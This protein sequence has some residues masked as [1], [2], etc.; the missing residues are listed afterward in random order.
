MRRAGIRCL[1]YIDDA[2]CAL[3]SSAEALAA[4]D[5]IEQMFAGSGLAKTPVK[6]V[7]EPTQSTD[8]L[9]AR[10]LESP[11]ASLPRYRIGCLSLAAPRQR[12]SAQGIFR[13]PA[14]FCGQV[15]KVLFKGDYPLLEVLDEKW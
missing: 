2:C 6:G 13:G 5:L 1:W 12:S 8:S 11:Y 9:P 10:A 14:C 15:K 3:P 7:W 4:R